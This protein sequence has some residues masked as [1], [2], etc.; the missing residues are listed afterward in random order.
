L[1]REILLE[2]AFKHGVSKVSKNAR[3]LIHLEVNG[4][5]LHF[6]VT[7]SKPLLQEKDEAGYTEGIGLKNV[8]RRLELLYPSVYDFNLFEQEEEFRIVLDLNL[9]KIVT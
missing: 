8:K 1:K 7:N 2:N 9:E 4:S 3:V 6:E 5:D